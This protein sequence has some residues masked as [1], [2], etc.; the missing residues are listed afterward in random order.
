MV[1]ALQRRK[2]VLARLA[3]ERGID[4]ERIMVPVLD[5]KGA[6][7]AR[8]LNDR[9]PRF[10]SVTSILPRM[11]VSRLWLRRAVSMG[12]GRPLHDLEASTIAKTDT[13]FVMGTG[14]SINTFPPEW[15]Q[16]IRAHSSIGMN[17][18]TLHEHVPSIHVFESTRGIRKD[19]LT[20]RVVEVGDYRSVPLI[21]KT[22]L[23]NFASKRVMRRL[24]NLAALPKPVRD[25]I[26]LSL[27]LNVAGSNA[28]AIES[29]YRA[30]GRFGLFSP[31][32]RFL[33]LTK[34]GGSVT[35]IINLAVRLGFTRIVLCG[36]DLNHTEYFYDPLKRE[37]EEKGLLVPEN[38]QP[39]DVH[40]TNDPELTDITV[41]EV[42]LSMK[43]AVLDPAGVELLVALNSSA[44]HPDLDTFDWNSALLQLDGQDVITPSGSTETNVGTGST[45]RDDNHV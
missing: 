34:R 5:Q 20:K 10:Y 32:R 17:F 3:R 7:L 19:V 8:W 16:L 22:Q 42:I 45:R 27:D 41:Q 14:S 38:V 13:V 11:V 43:R 36:I 12:V 30:L 2:E 39:T 21:A 18:F 9:F 4:P 44:L 35:Y 31:K 1:S 6:G 37:L 15:W 28:K 26:Y 23:S 29:S 24:G 40:N 33:Y 25:Q